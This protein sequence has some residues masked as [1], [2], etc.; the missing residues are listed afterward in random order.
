MTTKEPRFVNLGDQPV[1]VNHRDGHQIVVRPFREMTFD[2]RKPEDC[3]CVGEHYRQFVGILVPHPEDA[4][5]ATKTEPAVPVATAGVAGV[6]AKA[7]GGRYRITGDVV[8]ADGKVK[9]DDPPPTPADG[10]PVDS[11]DD[12]EE[13]VEP[14]A[15]GEN[16]DEDRPLEDVPSVTKALAKKLITAGFKSA[17]AL[18]QCQTATKVKKLAKAVGDKD[19]AEKIIGEAQDLLG[20]VDDDG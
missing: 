1:Y 13:A 10:E 7:A 11:D 18:A 8:G 14:E 17:D 3:I 20:Y 5:S 9:T 4:K 12:Q 6:A 2:W 15:A 19:L 16:D